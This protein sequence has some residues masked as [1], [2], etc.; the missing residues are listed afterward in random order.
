MTKFDASDLHILTDGVATIRRVFGPNVSAQQI[1]S[2][3]TRDLIV[4]NAVPLRVHHI[5]TW[6]V[7]SSAKDWLVQPDG[8]VSL[9]NFTQIIP[10]P[11]AGR[12][13]CHSEIF[14]TAFADAVA[15]GGGKR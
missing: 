9:R 1:A 4:M 12:E 5:D 6:W 2:M 14:L 3:L 10:F 15:T 13:A 11:D 8:S 7:I